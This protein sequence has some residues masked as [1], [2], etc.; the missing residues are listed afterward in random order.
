[1]K[2]SALFTL[3]VLWSIAAFSQINYDSLLS[4]KDNN[5]EE[6]LVIKAGLDSDTFNFNLLSYTTSNNT[7]QEVQYN[8]NYQFQRNT[9]SVTVD[10]V[11]FDCSAQ[12]LRNAQN[13]ISSYRIQVTCDLRDL[14]ELHRIDG[15]FDTF[16]FYSSQSKK[17]RPLKKPRYYRSFIGTIQ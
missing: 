14:W 12:H 5:I 1:M 8:T 16:K 11:S 2:T 10:T 13:E 3:F 15:E 9:V 4:L 17:G 7:T 6:S